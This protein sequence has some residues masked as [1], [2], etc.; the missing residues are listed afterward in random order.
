MIDKFFLITNNPYKAEEIERIVAAYGISMYHIDFK[1]NEL[2]TSDIMLLVRNKTLQ[3]FERYRLPVI[4][5]HAGLYINCLSG[6]PGA[7]TQLFWDNLEDKICSIVNHFNDTVAAASTAIGVCDGKRIYLKES[8]IAGNIS[9][10][11]RGTRS[12]QWDTIFIPDGETKT[13]AE[14]TIDEKNQISQGKI[15][16]TDIFQELRRIGII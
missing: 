3:A 12:F 16:I 15:A 1:I 4:V 8:R 10:S 6:M 14:M 7:L 11:P 13:Y 2:Q 9:D 5:D